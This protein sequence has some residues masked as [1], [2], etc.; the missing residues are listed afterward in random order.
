[1]TITLPLHT[2]LYV[3]KN[4]ISG[5]D[6]TQEDYQW[7]HELLLKYVLLSCFLKIRFV[8]GYR[9]WPTLSSSSSSSSL[10]NDES[11]PYELFIVR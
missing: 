3:R 1:M 2:Q 11:A 6:R 7:R 5:A 8:L 10:F 9:D 4:W